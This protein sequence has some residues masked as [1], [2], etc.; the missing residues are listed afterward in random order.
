VMSRRPPPP[1][2]ERML[3]PEEVET[4]GLDPRFRWMNWKGWLFPMSAERSVAPF[5]QNWLMEELNRKI[6]A[7]LVVTGRPGI[8]KSYL[9]IDIAR[10][11]DPKFTVDQVVFTYDGY[12]ELIRKL[13]M[14][15]VI[16]F[17]EPSY[18]MSHREWYK[19]LNRVLVKTMESQR[20]KIHPVLIPVINKALL[21]KT[22]RR[23]L[24]QYQVI[25]LDRGMATVYH[26]DPSQFVDRV[27]HRK[28]GELNYVMADWALCDRDSCVGCRRLWKTDDEGRYVCGLFRA[29]YERKKQTVQ[30]TRYIE[31]GEEVKRTRQRAL[32]DMQ[33]E[34][35]ILQIKNRVLTHRTQK[36]F[37]D[38]MATT[39]ELEKEYGITLPPTR[40]ERVLKRL[41]TK[42][43]EEFGPKKHK[44]QP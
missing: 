20:F 12:F 37:V 10:V 31:A 24:I 17:D 34:K 7:N 42:Y 35:M 15:R 13:P 6:P 36:G 38:Y 16:V 33:V 1:P 39:V 19:E 44:S 23:H 43:P 8:G 30:D 32:A 4:L 21:D 18:A 22:I 29:E 28:V 5:F 3:S 14:R 9:A 26:I 11:L 27:Y 25:V 2:S 41:R 40:V